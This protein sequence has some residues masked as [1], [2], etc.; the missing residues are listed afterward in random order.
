MSAGDAASASARLSKP[1]LEPSAGSS[2]VD[3]DVECEQIADRVRVFGAVQPVQRR[4]GQAGH[5]IGRTIEAGLEFGGEPVEHP[6]IGRGAPLG[7]IMPVRIFLTTFSQ[8][9]AS[10][11]TF[12]TSNESSDRLPVLS[13]WL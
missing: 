9:S 5:R 6:A 12:A 11:P 10:G 7:G 13:R 3:V 8:T 4:R 1:W 2:V